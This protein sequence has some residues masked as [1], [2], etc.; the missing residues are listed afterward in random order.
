MQPGAHGGGAITG[1]FGGRIAARDPN[2]GQ[3]V[4]GNVFGEFAASGGG[5]DPGFVTARVQQALLAATNDVIVQKLAAGQIAVPTIAHSLPALAGEIVHASGLAQQGIQ[6]HNL[7]INANVEPPAGAPQPYTG[8]M[9][10]DPMTAAANAF[11]QRAMEELDPRNRE[12]QVDVKVGG[13][14]L[15]ASTDEGFDTDGLKDQI[16]DKA[17]STVIWWGIGCFILA[18]VGAGVLAIAWYVYTQVMATS[19]GEIP[20]TSSSVTD[21]NWD[22]KSPLLCGAGQNLRISNV[23][24]NLSSGTAITASAN[25]KLELVG[26]SITAPTALSVLGTADVTVKGGSLKGSDYA[27]KALGANAK[28]KLEGTTVDGKK[29]ALGG[30]SITGP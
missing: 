14:K 17:K 20:A 27:V 5:G 24:A 30:A 21:S 29:Q 22:G 9:P 6:I 28:V 11:Q 3:P 7:Q 1:K 26:V 19:R 2:T 25:C 15:S 18:I 12:Y 16:A 10:P 4:S 8:P 23:T 13:F